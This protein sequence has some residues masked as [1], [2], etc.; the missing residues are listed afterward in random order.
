MGMSVIPVLLIVGSLNLSHIIGWQA[1]HGWLVFFSPVSFI[2]FLVA[3]FPKP[4]ACRSICPRRKPSWSAAI[5]PNTA[6]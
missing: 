3:S 5:T 2:I 1:Q 4:T 6:Q